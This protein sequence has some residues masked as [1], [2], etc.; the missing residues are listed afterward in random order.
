VNVRFHRYEELKFGKKGPEL[1]DPDRTNEGTGDKFV[2]FKMA[3]S[4]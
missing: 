2:K 1:E 3:S 4:L